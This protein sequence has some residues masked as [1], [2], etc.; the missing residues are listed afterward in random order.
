IAQDLKIHRKTAVAALGE[1]QEQ[2][3]IR[4]IPGVGSFVLDAEQA[5][6]GKRGRGSSPQPPTKAVF[7]FKKD[8]VLDLPL[9]EISQ[10]LYFT[11]GTPDYK[12]VPL[13]ELGRA[14]ASVLRRET[15]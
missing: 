12:I 11:D 13:E 3:C 1:L 2:G 4:I 5:R 7:D 14:Y 9:S 6:K 15:R 8:F 10:P